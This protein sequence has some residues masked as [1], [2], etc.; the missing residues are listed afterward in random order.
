VFGSQNLRIKSKALLGYT[1]RLDYNA[2][3]RPVQENCFDSNPKNGMHS[4]FGS[5]VRML[6]QNPKVAF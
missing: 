1:R 3:F 5:P 4:D 2:D 6:L